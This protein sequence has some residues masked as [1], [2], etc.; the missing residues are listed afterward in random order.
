MN[1]DLTADFGDSLGTARGAAAALSEE[2]AAANRE[3]R[4][5]DVQA[6]RLSRSLGSSLR[7]AFDRAIFGGRG[8][9]SVL[10]SLAQDVASRSLSAA[11]RPVTTGLGSALSSAFGAVGN[12][13]FGA[14]GFERGAAFSAGKVRAF[15]DGGIV[16]GPLR[17]PMSDGGVGL[18]GE[19]GPEAILPLGRGAD[20]R[21]GVRSVGG[22]ASSPT[23]VVNISTPDAES[24]RRSRG[25]VAAQLARAVARGNRQL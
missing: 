22:R 12:A 15:A 17:F 19:A 23:V 2:L 16:G 20:G 4:A 25:Q 3:M 24:F 13:A 11:L 7:T 10:R 6:G 9:G 18:M 21:L 1:D 8:L 14:L 5:M